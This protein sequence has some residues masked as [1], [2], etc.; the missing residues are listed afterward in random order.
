M[1]EIFPVRILLLDKPYFLA[2]APVLDLFFSGNGVT[3]TGELLHKHQHRDVV[4]SSKAFLLFRSVLQY[5]TLEIV[6]DADI[7]RPGDV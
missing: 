6:R 2:P 3:G 4:S 1:R 7:E 5:S